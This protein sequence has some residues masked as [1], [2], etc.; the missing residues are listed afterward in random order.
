MDSVLE[1]FGVKGLQQPV[2]KK[3]LRLRERERKKAQ[4]IHMPSEDLT[5]FRGAAIRLRAGL[6]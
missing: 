6:M 2:R 5:E 1:F 4:T 3:G